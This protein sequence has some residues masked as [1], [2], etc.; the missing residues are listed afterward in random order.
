MRRVLKIGALVAAGVLALL[1]VAI[2]LAIGVRPIIGARSRPLTDRRFDSTPVRLERGRYLVTSVS[3][4]LYCHGELD[5]QAPG[6]PVKAGTEGGGRRWDREGLPFV[7]APN[8][9][10]DRDTGAGAWYVRARDPR[11]HRS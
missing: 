9:T 5:W 6:F 11:G 8:I 4:C 7:T 3:G 10:P 1:A 2:P